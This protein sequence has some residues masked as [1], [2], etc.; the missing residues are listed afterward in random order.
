MKTSSTG[1]IKYVNMHYP[2]SSWRMKI[3]SWK[4]KLQVCR[5]ELCGVSNADRWLGKWFRKIPDGT[6]QTQQAGG[7]GYG[8]QRLHEEN[9]CFMWVR[10]QAVSAS[11]YITLWILGNSILMESD[12]VSEPV[13]FLR[14]SSSYSTTYHCYYFL[15][16]KPHTSLDFLGGK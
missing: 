8:G 11:L 9:R 5:S 16:I 1:K 14:I 15:C 12:D 13:A 2:D 7:V 3:G 4:R 6:Q 10:R